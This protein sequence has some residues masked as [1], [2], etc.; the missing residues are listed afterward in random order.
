MTTY[1]ILCQMSFQADDT[2]NSP[3]N[4]PIEAF[5]IVWGNLS[6]NALDFTE[7]V[8]L[9]SDPSNPCLKLAFD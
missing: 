5:Y 7:E 9:A 1:L 6:P 8:G 4:R 2:H 3:G